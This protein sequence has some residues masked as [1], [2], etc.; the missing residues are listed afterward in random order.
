[1]CHVTRRFGMPHI[2]ESQSHNIY[3]YS[4][5]YTHVYIHIN[6]WAY[7]FIHIHIYTHTHTGFLQV[8]SAELRGQSN[9]AH[10]NTYLYSY[11][12]MY[13]YMNKC[14]DLYTYIH[15]TCTCRRYKT[16]RAVKYVASRY[17]STYIYAYEFTCT[18]HT[19]RNCAG[20]IS[21]FIST[22]MCVYEFT[23]Y[24]HTGIAQADHPELGEQS[25]MLL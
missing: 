19:Y 23:L 7:T 22:Y 11:L 5:M 3:M 8:Q 20:R 6:I 13:M 21:G 15:R 12:H 25:H 14:T 17:I 1:M 4:H 2:H 16:T 18:T 24:R 10:L 9:V